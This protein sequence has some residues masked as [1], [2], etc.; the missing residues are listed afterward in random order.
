MIPAAACAIATKDPR[1]FVP[2][3]LSDVSCFF[4][5]PLH[6]T[7]P[8]TVIPVPSRGLICTKPSLPVYVNVEDTYVPIYISTYTYSYLR[9]LT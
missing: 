1:I 3:S 9:I 2:L 4:L 5:R 6:Q 8:G 7:E